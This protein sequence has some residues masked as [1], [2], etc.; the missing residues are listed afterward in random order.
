MAAARGHGAFEE[1]AQGEE[2]RERDARRVNQFEGGTPLPRRHPGW[3][4][5]AGAVRQATEED[6]FSREGGNALAVY[7][8][9]LAILRVPRIVDGDRA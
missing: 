5:G 9:C 1:G 2:R 6:P 4:D 3:D 8:D 7:C